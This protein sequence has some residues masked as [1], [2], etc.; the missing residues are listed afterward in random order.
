MRMV[1]AH[2]RLL[3]LLGL[4]VLLLAACAPQPA[5]T[6]TPTKTP[7]PQEAAVED[8]PVAA[9]TATPEPGGTPTATPLPGPYGPTGY[10]ENVN[11]LTGLP[12]DDVA[13]LERR[14]LLIKVSNESD[15]VRPQSGLA[16]ADHVWE[17]QM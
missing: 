11:P 2:F 4:V 10:P 17:Y 3:T 6:P 7:I 15:R 12:V 14:P 1:L 8:Q 13:V 5:V 9:P 16:F